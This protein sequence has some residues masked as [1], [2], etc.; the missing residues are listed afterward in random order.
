[1]TGVLYV[2][3]ADFFHR[4]TI[5]AELVGHVNMRTAMQFHR[6]LEEFQCRLAIPFLGD[7]GF[8]NL[9]FVVHSA[10]KDV[11]DTVDLCEHLVQMPAPVGQGPHSFHAFPPDLG[12]E[13]RANSVPTELNCLM[14][15]FDATLMQKVLNVEQ[16]EREVDVEHHR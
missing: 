1:M 8:K 16:R 4:S 12:G 6:F 15:D 14:A 3:V 11:R 5:R 13:H 2:R 10:P 9:A 7:E